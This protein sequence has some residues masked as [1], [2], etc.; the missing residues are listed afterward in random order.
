MGGAL[1][2]LRRMSHHQFPTARVGVMRI[3]CETYFVE[4]VPASRDQDPDEST[5]LTVDLTW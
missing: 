1:A 5:D 3:I 2:K 4:G